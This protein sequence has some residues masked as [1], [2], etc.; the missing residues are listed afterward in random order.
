MACKT[1]EADN[2]MKQYIHQMQGDIEGILFQTILSTSQ[3]LRGYYFRQ[4]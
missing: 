4:Y 1:T 2:I 3:G